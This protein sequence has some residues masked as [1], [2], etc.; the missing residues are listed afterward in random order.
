MRSLRRR[1]SICAKAFLPN[2]KLE[3]AAGAAKR[4]KSAVEAKP[5]SK[6]PK[7][8]GVTPAKSL[9]DLVDSVKIMTY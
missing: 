1:S 7:T 2:F 8:K 9:A 6:K 5:S 4:Q 3:A